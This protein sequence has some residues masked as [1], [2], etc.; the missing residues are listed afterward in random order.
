MS[1]QPVDM[2]EVQTRLGRRCKTAPLRE[3][4]A[5]MAH[6]D[7]IHVDYYNEQTGEGYKPSTVAQ[8]VGSLSRASGTTR[9][10][11]R[12]D[13]DKSGCYVLCLKR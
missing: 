12:K 4:L 11:V 10:S 9:F 13:P 1:I 2:S 7:A 6:D 5:Q 8:V 3:A